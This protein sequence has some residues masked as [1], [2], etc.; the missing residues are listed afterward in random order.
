MIASVRLSDMDVNVRTGHDVQMP[1]T[2]WEDWRH[3]SLRTGFTAALDYRAGA[4][5]LCAANSSTA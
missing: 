3:E 5:A 2:P 4:S 1:F